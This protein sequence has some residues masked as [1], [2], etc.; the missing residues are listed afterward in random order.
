MVP[1][2]ILVAAVSA[3]LPLIAGG[4]VEASQASTLALFRGVLP[5]SNHQLGAATFVPLTAPAITRSG[6]ASTPTLTWSTVTLTNGAPVSYVVMRVPKVG[7]PVEVC[8]GADAPALSGS[9]VSC[10]DRVHGA[11]PNDRYTEQPYLLRSGQVTW[12]LS[13]S[14]PSA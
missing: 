1:A 6:L 3:P 9:T 14:A 12:T 7:T 13:A 10:V 5:N 4:G 11:N 2:L 8:K